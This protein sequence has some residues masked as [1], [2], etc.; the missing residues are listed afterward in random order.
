MS[1]GTRRSTTLFARSTLVIAALG[2]GGRFEVPVPI[3]AAPVAAPPPSEPATI[4]L[5]IAIALSKIRTQLDSAFPPTDSLDRAKCTALGGL[6]CHQYLYQRDSLDLRISGDRVVLQTR[7]RFRAAIG[8]PGVG[9]IASCGFPPEAMKRADVR[10]STSLFWRSDWRLGARGTTVTAQLADRCQVTLLRFDATPMM[11]RLVDAQTAT[12]RQQIDSV[13][14]AV[15]NLSPVADSLWHL[16]QVP[17]ALDSAETIW[18]TMS[19]ETV[20]LLP[21]A[22]SASAVATAIVLTARP[23]VSIGPKPSPGTRSLPSLTLA[24]RSAGIHVPVEIELPFSDLSQKVTTLLAGEVAG[25]GISIGDI[26]V[27]GVGD[28]AVVMVALEG[29]VNGSLYLLGR[30]SYD[31]VSRAVLLGDLRYTLASHDAM[32]R[33]K[34]TLGANRIKSAVDAATGR[35]RLAVGEQLDSLKSRMTQELNRPV[36]P[37]VTLAGGVRDVRFVGLFTTQTAFVLRV[38]LDGEAVLLVQ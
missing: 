17:V 15:A 26:K 16:L 22:G 7:L 10:L 36:A 29:K 5:P 1:I 35:G 18:L 6:V 24:R 8:L 20:S 32:S 12:L 9:G 28:T 11:K 27:W 23:R 38:V 14:P 37:G 34:S 33:I 30:V 13:I 3:L 2:C 19:P 25:K 4:T 31:S 21:I